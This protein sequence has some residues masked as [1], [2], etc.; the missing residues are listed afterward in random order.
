MTELNE[1]TARDYVRLHK[2]QEKAIEKDLEFNPFHEAR[3]SYAE[4]RGYLQAL[5]QVKPLVEALEKI[6]AQTMPDLSNDMRE[7]TMQLSGLW[8]SLKMLANQALAA[9]RA[10][11]GEK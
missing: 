11:Q 7:R 2:H 3:Y 6:D 5:E 10:T 8:V 4:A 1:K 9:Y